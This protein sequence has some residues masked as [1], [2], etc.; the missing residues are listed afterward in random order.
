MIMI[1][2]MILLLLF[3]YF[4]YY[5]YI[6]INK[7]YTCSFRE[8]NLIKSEN[9]RKIRIIHSIRHYWESL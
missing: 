3:I 5:Y 4:F 1:M 7:S 8:V 2:M 6:H 9:F